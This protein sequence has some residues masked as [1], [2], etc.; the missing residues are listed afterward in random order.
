MELK[1]I[2]CSKRKG[3]KKKLV[4][5]DDYSIEGRV[6]TRLFKYR[7]GIR[8]F[9]ASNQKMFFFKKQFLNNNKINK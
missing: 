7:I 5:D 4:H 3:K 9:A 2:N 8:G 6:F 1:L